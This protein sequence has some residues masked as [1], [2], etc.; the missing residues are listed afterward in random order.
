MRYKGLFFTLFL[1]L[2]GANQAYIY[3]IKVLR[4]WDAGRQKYH[5]FIGLS[6]FH[7]KHSASNQSQLT[8]IEQLLGSL[9]KK[10]VMLA[11]EDL[12]SPNA[13]GRQECGH[14]SINSRGG[15]Y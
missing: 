9:D 6:D 4:K 12:S 2:F 13:Q 1:G 10:R 14:F 11:V 8:K 5:Y 7:D 15:G 3:E